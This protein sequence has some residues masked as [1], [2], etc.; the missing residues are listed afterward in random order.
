[1][2]DYTM[3]EKSYGILSKWINE[4]PK[5]WEIVMGIRVSS[6]RNNARIFHSL[7]QAGLH[8]LSGMV[9]FRIHQYQMDNMAHKDWDGG[10]EEQPF[11]NQ[12]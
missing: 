9:A 8:Q 6:L 3:S 7:H 11:K 1:M 10:E 4:N 12:K 5:D 2:E